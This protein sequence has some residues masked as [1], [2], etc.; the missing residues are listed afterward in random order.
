MSMFYLANAYE[1]AVALAS[2][3]F[4]RRNGSGVR[5]SVVWWWPVMNLLAFA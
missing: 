3:C 4:K 1:M 5:Q 2:I